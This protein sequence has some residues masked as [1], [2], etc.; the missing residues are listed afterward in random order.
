ML[1]AILALMFL[2][3][4]A[5]T[6]N[7]YR[8]DGVTLSEADRLNWLACKG[9]QAKA[10]TYGGNRAGDAVIQGCMADRGYVWR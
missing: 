10:F 7:W 5:Q 3:G 2:T 8:V 1:R 4:C 6:G 9:E